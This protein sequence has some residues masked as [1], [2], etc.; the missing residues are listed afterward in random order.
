M[1]G[2]FVTTVEWDTW[3][4]VAKDGKLV[5]DFDPFFYDRQDRKRALVEEKGLGF[6]GDDP[7]VPSWMFLDRL[8]SVHVE[9]E[10]F[11]NTPHPTYVLTGR[12]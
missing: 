4:R 10:W 5:R 8:T 3:I 6:G 11:Y 1:A 9:K 12:G 2:A 7:F